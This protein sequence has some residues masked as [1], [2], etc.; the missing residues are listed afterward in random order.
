M[1]YVQDQINLWKYQEDRDT[2][3]RKGFGDALSTIAGGIQENRKRALESKRKVFDIGKEFTTAGV[4]PTQDELME[5]ESTG[6]SQ[7][8]LDRYAPIAEQER[9]RKLSL[10]NAQNKVTLHKAN[11]LDLPHEQRDDFIKY[12]A[13]QKARGSAETEKFIRNQEAQ[14]E[15]EKRRLENEKQAKLDEAKVQDF[16][17]GAPDIIP[18]KKDAE[19]VKKMNTATQN[20]GRVADEI[21]TTLS[22]MKSTSN[23]SSLYKLKIKLDQKLA[24]ARLQQ[25]TIKDLGVL[26]GPDLPLVDAT[27]GDAGSITK[28]LM[29]GPDEAAKRVEEAKI[30]AQ[31]NLDTESNAR[32]YKRRMPVQ[33]KIKTYSP[34]QLAARRA[35]LEA[36]EAAMTAGR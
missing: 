6:Y 16:D 11:Q 21:K 1:A 24:E 23:P 10:S 33:E 30:A 18:T 31:R 15:A 36:K 12:T 22:E 26:N 19:S 32:G 3:T 9:Q 25:K 35:E 13:G 20:F 5:L 29:L 7:P 34:E 27:L 17:F 2:A 28:L 8:L 14:V 4:A